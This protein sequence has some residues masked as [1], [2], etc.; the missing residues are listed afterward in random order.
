MVTW[1]VIASFRVDFSECFSFTYNETCVV[2]CSVG[3]T[4]VGDKNTTEFKG[5]S[6]G[7]FQGS[8]ERAEESLEL[9]TVR[10][11]AER[12]FPCDEHFVQTNGNEFLQS[13]GV[14][15]DDDVDDDSL[16]FPWDLGRAL[17]TESEAGAL[18]LFDGTW[19]DGSEDAGQFWHDEGGLDSFKIL[20]AEGKPSVL[21]SASDETRTRKAL[22]SPEIRPG[23]ARRRALVKESAAPMKESAGSVKERAAHVKE[24]AT[25]SESVACVPRVS[26]RPKE[27]TS[28]LCLRLV[29]R[30]SEP[31]TCV[32]PGGLCRDNRRAF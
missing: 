22:V 2:R 19:Q 27:K 13:D 29:R 10:T 1:D 28:V 23:S 14:A 26:P 4:G 15:E 21:S 8:L 24:F 12:V 17:S 7:H 32:H 20:P 18:R 31:R 11:L 9:S 25:P 5:D 16:A 6:H 30:C 3:Y